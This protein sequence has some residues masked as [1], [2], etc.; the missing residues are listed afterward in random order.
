ML[1]NEKAFTLLE[2]LIVLLIISVLIILIVPNLSSSSKGID[3]KGCE[4][5]VSV[6]QT[7]VNLFYLEKRRY[8]TNIDEMVKS[9]YLTAD[10]IE[11]SNNEKFYING[12]GNVY[13]Q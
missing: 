8:P 3:D 7:Q 13:K 5:L 2:M 6:V 9:N 4:A 1:K 10:Q 11:C 12:E